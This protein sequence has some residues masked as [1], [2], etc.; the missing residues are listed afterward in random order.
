MTPEEKVESYLERAQMLI[1]KWL[2]D[3]GPEELVAYLKTPHGLLQIAKMI[4]EEEII[5]RGDS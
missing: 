3:D 1:N 4:Q 5:D 2:E